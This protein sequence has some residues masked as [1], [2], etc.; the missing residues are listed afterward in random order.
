MYT[1]MLENHTSQQLIAGLWLFSFAND[2]VKN[3]IDVTTG[4]LKA[5]VI[6][7]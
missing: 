2:I 4:I 7:I 3:K 1:I 5:A 6:D